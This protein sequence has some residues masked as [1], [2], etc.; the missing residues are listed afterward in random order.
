MTRCFIRA[1]RAVLPSRRTMST[2]PALWALCVSALSAHAA[3]AQAS[4]EPSFK[5]VVNAANPVSS[6]SREELSRLFLKKVTSWRDSKPVALV[7]QRVNNPVRESFTRD[8]HGRQVGSV[9]SFWLQMIFAGR[10]IPPVEKASDVDVAAFVAAN[11]AAIGYVSA[12]A[13]LPSGVKA[14]AISR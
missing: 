7:D 13:D 9:T 3:H 6:L 8:V 4:T 14:I 12:N 11:P 5:I 10:A 2:V 1:I